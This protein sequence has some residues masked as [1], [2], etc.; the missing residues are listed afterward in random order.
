[1]T[2]Y[3]LVTIAMDEI[4]ELVTG[5]RIATDGKFE[6]VWLENHFTCRRCSARNTNGI[7]LVYLLCQDIN[8]GLPSDKW[9][10]IRSAVRSL[11]EKG[12]VK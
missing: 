9:D 1:M 11:I 10:I 2:K 3:P 5:Q 7:H 6:V 4:A 12:V 8:E